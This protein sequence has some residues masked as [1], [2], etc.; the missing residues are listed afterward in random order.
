MTQRQFKSLP[1]EQF[2]DRWQAA[3]ETLIGGDGEGAVFQYKALAIDGC[4]SA[5]F[6]LGRIYEDGLC[7]VE[8]DFTEA[9]TWFRHSIE[10]VDDVAS[11]LAVARIYLQTTEFDPDRSLSKYHL[12]LLAE[13]GVP[14][15]NFGLGLMYHHGLGVDV[16]LKQ[17]KDFYRS[18]A[19]SGHLLANLRLTYL[20]FV[21]H[22]IKKALPLLRAWRAVRALTRKAPYDPRL[23]FFDDPEP[24]G[25]IIDLESGRPV[26]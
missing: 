25:I 26:D 11:H 21:E 18:S 4:A 14:A 17:A 9:L 2:E 7:G 10:T 19:E 1:P 6:Q 16:D 8:Q 13:N 12:R 20:E 3:L 24:G 5:L 23:G 15:G 22:P